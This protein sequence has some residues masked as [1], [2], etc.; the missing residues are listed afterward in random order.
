M[1]SSDKIVLRNVIGHV[2]AVIMSMAVVIR[3]VS[4]D[5][6]D[7]IAMIEMSYQVFTSLIYPFNT[8]QIISLIY[9]CEFS[10]KNLNRSKINCL[11]DL[12]VY[13]S[14]TSKIY[15]IQINAF[16]KIRN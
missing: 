16:V 3:D 15:I 8:L 9:I 1:D 13:N 6:R 7:T 14:G 4:Q 11:D 2:Q 5:G 12:F 10:T